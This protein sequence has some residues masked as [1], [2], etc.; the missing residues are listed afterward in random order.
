MN[1]IEI[2]AKKKDEIISTLSNKSFHSINEII[3]VFNIEWDKLIKDI[4]DELPEKNAF[5]IDLI[6]LHP[7]ITKYIRRRKNKSFYSIMYKLVFWKSNNLKYKYTINT[8]EIYKHI[9]LIITSLDLAIVKINNIS[10]VPN[11]PKTTYVTI[12][13]KPVI[14]FNQYEELVKSYQSIISDIYFCKDKNCASLVLKDVANALYKQGY[15][16]IE[17]S[18][19]HKK[20][21]EIKYPP[22]CTEP[23]MISPTICD[24]KTK[25]IIVKGIV[26]LPKNN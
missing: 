12:E 25:E 23:L 21:F 15:D 9:A 16:V 11:Q 26:Y 2:L 6:K 4:S 1:C 24:I 13:G 17:Y 14:P 8:G 20:Y 18:N 7:S 3:D 22:E 5:L 10:N 19:E